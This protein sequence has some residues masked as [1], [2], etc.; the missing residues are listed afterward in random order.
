[1]TKTVSYQYGQVTFVKGSVTITHDKLAFIIPTEQVA[2][3]YDT[4]GMII[5]PH[6]GKT[7]SGKPI[8]AD[9]LSTILKPIVDICQMDGFKT[10]V[11]N[12][13]APTPAQAAFAL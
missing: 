8:P 5:F 11:A 10:R 4:E 9:L 3:S 2:V 1:M 6:L 12:E 7:K 13:G